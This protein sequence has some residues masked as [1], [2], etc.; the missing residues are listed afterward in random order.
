MLSTRH[1]H[2]SK[3]A[4]MM[5][6][7]SWMS[8]FTE[9]LLQCSRLCAEHRYHHSKQGIHDARLKSAPRLCSLS[10]TLFRKACVSPALKGTDQSQSTRGESTTCR[11]SEEHPARRWATARA[12]PIPSVGVVHI[13]LKRKGQTCWS[14]PVDDPLGQ[15]TEKD[16]RPGLP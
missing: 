11:L 10:H 15:G 1:P 3:V 5:T 4:T 9:H 2:C 6:P 13:Q 8:S 7:I 12:P 16:P 14:P